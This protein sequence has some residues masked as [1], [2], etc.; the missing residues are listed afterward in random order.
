MGDGSNLPNESPG[1]VSIPGV[2]KFDVAQAHACAIHNGGDSVSCWGNRL[3]GRLG[4]DD[5]TPGNE[6]TP[7]AS[8]R[9]T[10]DPV[11]EVCT[12]LAFTCIATSIGEV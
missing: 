4:N 6:V 5:S 11:V 12:G 8:I 10:V 2:L 1:L 9:P 7:V 3:N